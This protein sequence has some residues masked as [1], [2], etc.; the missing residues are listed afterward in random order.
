MER[1]FFDDPELHTQTMEWAIERFIEMVVG[2]HNR[3]NQYKEF[4]HH[5]ARL[6]GNQNP[7]EL[8]KLSPIEQ[9]IDKE[10]GFY[11]ESMCKAFDFFME[12]CIQPIIPNLETAFKK[13]T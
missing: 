4:W 1:I 13:L 10:T 3:Q 11:D 6:T 9:M 2:S 12:Y 7:Q 8:S 5:Y